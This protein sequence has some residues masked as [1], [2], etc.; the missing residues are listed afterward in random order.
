MNV[1]LKSK[2]RANFIS[3]SPAVI[4]RSV[5]I[6]KKNQR[7]KVSLIVLI[8]SSLGLLDLAGVA[9]VGLVGALAVTGVQSRVPGNRVGQVLNLLNLENLTIQQQV[10]FLGLLAAIL[11]IVRT[12]LSIVLSRK[13]LY[14]LARCGAEIS[15]DL[16]EK[17]LTQP[18]TK[19]QTNSSQETL[20]A[21]TNGVTAITLGL[22]AV[23]QTY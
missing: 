8:Q 11:F 9:A 20:Y 1:N 22:L 13:I 3:I 6:L 7:R 18:L 16:V 10:A 5:K 17:M 12:I 19:I 15:G 14:F 21:L 23:L 4:L 2:I